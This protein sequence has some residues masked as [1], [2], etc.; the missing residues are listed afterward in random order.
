MYTRQSDLRSRSSFKNKI[1]KLAYKTGLI[2]A[3]RGLWARSLTVVNYHRIDDP[4]RQDFDSFKPN[5]SATPGDF[6]HQVEYLAKWFN[7]VSL[8]DIV[9]WLDGHKDLP[10][11]AALITFDDGYLD[12]YTSAFPI[13][14]RHN[15]PALIFLTTE[16]IGTD[17]PFYWDMAAY[18]FS[19]TQRDHLTFPDGRIVHWPGREQLD[20]VSKNW[21]ESM[22]TLPQAEKEFHVQRLPESLGVAVPEGFFRKLM[23]G[24][25][26]VR[27]MCKDGIEFGA[28]TMHH[29]ILTRVPLEQVREE[30]EGSK[31][32]IEKE[33]GESVLGFAYPNGQPSDLN[34]R[35]EKIVADSGI[36]A[37]FTLLNGPSSQAEVK[38]NPYAIRRIFISHKHSVSEYAMLLSPINRYRSN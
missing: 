33:L 29:P 23:M 19:H 18:C 26:Q 17:A 34:D 35:I 12:N 9:E 37:A 38:R 20:R 36:R 14:R 30:V 27:E 21:I 32:R 28:H 8:K 16:H 31:S 3:G 15:F 4:N 6:H 1:I 2:R 10:P 5:V 11:Y 24:W 7:V 22:K 25:D 13:L